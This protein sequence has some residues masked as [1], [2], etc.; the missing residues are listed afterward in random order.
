MTQ[1]NPLLKEKLRSMQA[2][3]QELAIQTPVAKTSKYSND[4]VK[5]LKQE[6]HILSFGTSID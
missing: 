1:Y 4:D 6:S 5:L 2:L 3:I